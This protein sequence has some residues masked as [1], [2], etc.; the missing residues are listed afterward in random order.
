MV[1]TMHFKVMTIFVL[2]SNIKV[3]HN[4]PS[5]AKTIS[6]WPSFSFFKERIQ[7]ITIIILL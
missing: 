6:K 4:F 2:Q 5:L 7:T 3:Q 1:E